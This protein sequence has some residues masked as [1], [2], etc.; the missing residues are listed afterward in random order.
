MQRVHVNLP[1]GRVAQD[2]SSKSYSHR[3]SCHVPR[4][5]F[6]DLGLSD[7][8]SQSLSLA[9]LLSSPWPGITRLLPVFPRHLPVPQLSAGPFFVVRRGDGPFSC[10]IPLVLDNTGP[11][12]RSLHLTHN[13][14]LLLSC[15]R[16]TD[17]L[18]ILSHDALCCAAMNEQMLMALTCKK[19]PNCVL[20]VTSGPSE[21]AKTVYWFSY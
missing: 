13:S 7:F 1:S 9:A 6:L 8:S 21:S 3:A 5:T 16:G 2:P 11:P 4:F 18:L 17:C 14:P 20:T 19:K 15:Q 10:L 12:A